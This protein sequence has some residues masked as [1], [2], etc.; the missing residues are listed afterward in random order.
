MLNEAER[1]C[2]Q[3]FYSSYESAKQNVPTRHPGTCEWL[4]T[5]S[6]FVQWAN[7]DGPKLLWI[8][9]NPGMGKTVLSKF[10]VQ[11]FESDPEGEGKILYYFF[12]DQEESRRSGVSLLR[13]LIHQCLGRWPGLVKGHI[14]PAFDAQGENLF[15]SLSALW[16][17][18][19]NLT[20]DERLACVTCV[21]ESHPDGHI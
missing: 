13:S 1:K 5:H 6:D 12:S 11:H 20:S 2:V 16:S 9:G 21:A 18:F 8:S 19:I 10:L 3:A 4:L 7:N 15:G 14:M 17:I